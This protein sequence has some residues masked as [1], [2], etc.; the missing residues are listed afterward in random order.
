MALKGKRKSGT[1]GSQ[2]RRRPAT[3]PRPAPAAG[4]H[5]P[6]Y[7]T[8]GGRLAIGIGIALV[9][10]VAWWAIATSQSNAD[11][12]EDRQATLEEYTGSIRAVSQGIT[13][14]SAEMAVVAPNADDGAVEG[15][16]ESSGRWAK[17]FTDAQGPLIESFP[18]SPALQRAN[19]L[20]Q[21]ALQLYD[22]AARTYGLVPRAEGQLRTD[23]LARAAAQR[24][25][26]TGLWSTAVAFLDAARAAAEMD[27]SGI[28]VPGSEAADAAQ[29]PVEL[30]APAPD[31]TEGGG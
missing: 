5:L 12:L 22:S 18:P 27:A 24:D 29:Q 20:F 2:G 17:S 31:A 15:L 25:Q 16:A 26:A 30:P 21:Q 13:Q 8:N 6:W 7:H 3:A 1:R 19:G 10:G 28:P 14:A 23:L 11:R 4:R 9:V